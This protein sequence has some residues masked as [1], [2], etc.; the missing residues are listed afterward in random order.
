[1]TERIIGR[2]LA[3]ACGL[4]AAAATV[5][6]SVASVHARPLRFVTGSGSTDGF[7]MFGWVHDLGEGQGKGYF[8]IILHRDSLDG[9]TVAAICHYK[10]FDQVQISD[11]LASFHSIGECELL[12]DNGRRVRFTSDNVFGI[13]DH[14]QPGPGLD[15]I[16]VNII[17]GTGLAVPGSFLVDG[18]FLV[19]Q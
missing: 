3:G 17:S 11:G 14:G 4:A 16:D 10:H 12:S 8:T 18:N 6:L 19:Q 15:T 13:G 7:S 2:R 1:M 9:T 5:L